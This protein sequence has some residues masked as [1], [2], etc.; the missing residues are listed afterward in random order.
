MRPFPNAVLPQ[1]AKA[2]GILKNLSHAANTCANTITLKNE[3]I[4]AEHEH[5][6]YRFPTSKAFIKCRELASCPFQPETIGRAMHCCVASSQHTAAPP[7]PSVPKNR[8]PGCERWVNGTGT[9]L[10]TQRARL[11]PA[12]ARAERGVPAWRSKH[13]RSPAERFPSLV[14]AI[15]QCFGKKNVT[16]PYSL[17]ISVPKQS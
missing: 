16:S 4:S 8:R 14:R 12:C 2:W 17:S 7:Q 5:P 9:C 1:Q 10:L 3:T 13:L 15:R 6:K 11:A